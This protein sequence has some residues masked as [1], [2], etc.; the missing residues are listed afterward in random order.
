MPR[1]LT[2]SRSAEDDLERAYLAYWLESPSLA[3]RFAGSVG[4]SVGLLLESPEAGRVRFDSPSLGGELRSWAVT[5]FPAH[6]IFYRPG[7]D[8]LLVVRLLHGARDL[9]RLLD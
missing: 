3:E 5:G 7:P 4:D 6:L 8:D 2:W 1:R 9:P